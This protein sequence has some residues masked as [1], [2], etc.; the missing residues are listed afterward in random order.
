MNNAGLIILASVLFIAMGYGLYWLMIVWDRPSNYY[1]G[2]R[3]PDIEQRPAKIKSKELQGQRKAEVKDAI[4]I[5]L[6]AIGKQPLSRLQY[7]LLRC[8]MH[9]TQPCLKVLIAEINSEMGGDVIEMGDKS[10]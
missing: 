2:F 6:L 10:A 1:R 3:I 5:I 4:I 8:G 9:V 7:E